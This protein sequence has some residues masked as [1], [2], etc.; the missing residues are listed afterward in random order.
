MSSEPSYSERSRAHVA[1]AKMV[2]VTSG[3]ASV[4]GFIMYR[5]EEL[6]AAKC[7][8]LEKLGKDGVGAYSSCSVQKSSDL[9]R[10][11]P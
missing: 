10:S 1:L 9:C 6:S 2:V 5:K 4:G 8:A 3:V 7:P 11:K